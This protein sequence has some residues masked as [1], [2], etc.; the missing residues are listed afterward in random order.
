MYDD[1]D[2]YDLDDAV[3]LTDQETNEDYT[4]NLN[5]TRQYLSEF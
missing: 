1:K 2:Y 5:G 3:I 4:V